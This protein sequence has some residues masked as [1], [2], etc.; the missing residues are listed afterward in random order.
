MNLGIFPS[1]VTIWRI[2]CYR[3]SPPE[4]TRIYLLLNGK[5]KLYVARERMN[6]FTI[7]KAQIR[8]K[9]RH[10]GLGRCDERHEAS[11]FVTDCPVI[12][13]HLPKEKVK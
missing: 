6:L 1:H 3:A 2:Q 7:K 8:E 12:P 11:M 5:F 10:S 9:E 4:R 13:D